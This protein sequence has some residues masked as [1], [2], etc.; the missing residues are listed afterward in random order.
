MLIKK[1]EGKIVITWGGEKMRM[2]WE[3]P[4]KQAVKMWFIGCKWAKK[5]ALTLCRI[6]SCLRWKKQ[7]PSVVD[8]PWVRWRHRHLCPFIYFSP[9]GLQT[10]NCTS[11]HH[12]HHHLFF[13]STFLHVGAGKHSTLCFWLGTN[14]VA[15]AVPV[16]E[17]L[18]KSNAPK[19]CA[20]YLFIYFRK[21]GF[22]KY[23]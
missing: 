13:I 6:I 1:R 9:C 5:C 23:R 17:R 14:V 18:I 22:S 11:Y 16:T 4:S 19:S 12:H 8:Q 10:L 2:T 15:A 21:Y 7:N 3:M 20:D